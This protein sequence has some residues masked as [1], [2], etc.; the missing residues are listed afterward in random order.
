MGLDDTREPRRGAKIAAKGIYRDPGCS[1]RGFLVKASG[2]RWLSTQ[3]VGT[4]PFER[5][6]ARG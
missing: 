1:S 5:R 2:W 3:G 4:Y 6:C